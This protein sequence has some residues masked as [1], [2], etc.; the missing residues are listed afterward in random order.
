MGDPNI[1]ILEIGTLN[2]F[3]QKKSDKETV[4]I[5]DECDKMLDESC[6]IF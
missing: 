5:L 4:F 3:P 1:Q 6:I 2:A